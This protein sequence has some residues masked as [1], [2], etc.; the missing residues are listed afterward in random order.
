[1]RVVQR[2]RLSPSSSDSQSFGCTSLSWFDDKL[3]VGSAAGVV[4][5]YKCP[6]GHRYLLFFV[7]LF[8]AK[9]IAER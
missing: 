3:L 7:V 9:L 5:F 8:Y 4:Q 6:F 2:F 1:M